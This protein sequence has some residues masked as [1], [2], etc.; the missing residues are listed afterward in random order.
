MKKLIARNCLTPLNDQ[1]KYSSA[2]MK[3]I[4]I[5]RIAGGRVLEM[6]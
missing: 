1:N 5:G 2:K 4:A 6:I 3:N